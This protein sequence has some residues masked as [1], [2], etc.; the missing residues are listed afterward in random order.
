[1]ATKI[2]FRLSKSGLEKIADKYLAT[3]VTNGSI[4]LDEVADQITLNRPAIDV[5]D[6]N[7]VV[8]AL[9]NEIAR[10]V[11]L[12]Y[13]VST[14]VG[15][16]GPAISGSVPSMDSALGEGNKIQTGFTVS[17]A[18]NAEVSA[19]RP[20]NDIKALDAFIDKVEDAQTH[21]VG[22]IVERNEFIVSG[23]G[24]SLTQT[25]EKIDLI[26]ADDSVLSLATYQP[27][28]SQPPMY[29]RASLA[30]SI[31]GGHYRIRIQTRGYNNPTGELT[32]LVKKV[33][34]VVA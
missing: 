11:G 34:V 9:R 33:D 27:T 32:T 18:V 22:T 17:P 30:S 28:G 15:Y 5:A 13:N 7:L 14:P 12:G 4:G 25:G 23:W 20:T 3:V 8:G 19:L 10:L 6:V 16:F 31:A 1:M 2:K 21:K 29:L 24:L 26:A